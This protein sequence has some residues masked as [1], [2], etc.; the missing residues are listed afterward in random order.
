[1]MSKRYWKALIV[2][3]L[4][5]S[6][7][8]VSSLAH[9]QNQGANNQGKDEVAAPVTLGGE[10]VFKIKKAGNYSP[11]E[12][13]KKLSEELKAK[14]EDRSIEINSLKIEQQGETTQIVLKDV[15]V[16][17]NEDDTQSEG[18]T[19]QQLADKYLE[20]IKLAITRYRDRE[21]LPVSLLSLLILSIALLIIVWPLIYPTI[22]LVL[23]DWYENFIN[24]KERNER[25]KSG[26]DGREESEEEILK[27][28][29]VGELDRCG[30]FIEYIYSHPHDYVIY[31]T[32]KAIRWDYLPPKNGGI[33]YSKRINQILDIISKIWSRN[34][35]EIERVETINKLTVYGIKLA[36]EDDI[37][38]SKKVLDAASIRL[39]DFRERDARLQYLLG[40]FYALTTIILAI[41][42]LGVLPGFF[43]RS[44]INIFDKFSVPREFIVVV[45][46]GAMG[47]FLSV[48]L[49]INRIEIETDSDFRIAGISRIF[50]AV[51]SSL[52]IYIALRAN[53]FSDLSKILL[54]VNGQSQKVDIWRVG[55]VSAAAGF[56]ETLVPNILN[57][58]SREPSK[59]PPGTGDTGNNP[60]NPPTP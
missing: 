58:S 5:L 43:D 18:L 19:K 8:T 41:L 60:P 12:R 53:L 51:I 59:E 55:F 11:Q 29:K 46:C 35:E 21:S 38:M 56:T 34:P 17:L 16:N 30:N 6:I 22:K 33:D 52:I 4:T 57:L 48:A 37:S 2:F 14:A 45:S 42:L 39:E 15:L 7:I 3:I 36:L 1:M 9:S 24:F 54:N 27:R 49:G 13:A 26:T 44:I 40:S 20:N 31:R 28:Y 32:K 25:Q 47:G 23:A 10:T 50:I